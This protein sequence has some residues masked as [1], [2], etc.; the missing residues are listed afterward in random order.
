MGLFI[1]VDEIHSLFNK[2][3]WCYKKFK[4]LLIKKIML[5]YWLRSNFNELWICGDGSNLLIIKNVEHLQELIETEIIIPTKN[6]F[7]IRQPNNIG[8]YVE[9]V[10]K[11]V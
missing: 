9:I 4:K 1:S 3:V 11:K 10:N 8:W 7:R 2:N 5:N 6:Y